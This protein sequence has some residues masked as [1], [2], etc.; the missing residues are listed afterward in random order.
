MRASLPERNK[1]ETR[2]EM[3]HIKLITFPFA[4]FLCGC[5]VLTYT[6][7]SGER[8]TRSSLGAN[9]V[10]S[11][12]ALETGTNGV[13]RV[14]LRGYQNDTAQTLGAITEAAVKAAIQ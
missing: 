1:K 4:L 3:K 5:Q 6:G 11:S 13:R 12:L 2:L 10:L 8:F 9:T 7:P 14:E